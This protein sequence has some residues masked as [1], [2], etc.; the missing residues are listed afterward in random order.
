[1]QADAGRFSTTTSAGI[2][3]TQVKLQKVDPPDEV[4]DAFR[5]VQAARADQERSINEAQSYRNE[6]VPRARGEAEQI[7]QEAEAYKQQVVAK[8]QGDAARFLSVYDQY[9]QAKDVTARRIYLETM[10]DILARL[11][12][13]IDRQ[14]RKRHRAS[15]PTCRCQQACRRPAATPAA[16]AAAAARSSGTGG[17]ASSTGQQ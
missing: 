6:I 9:S 1:M 7:I 13:I 5:D 4:I 16:S 8:A 17:T 14:Q 2:E 3:V 15:C 11:N 12:K 10:E